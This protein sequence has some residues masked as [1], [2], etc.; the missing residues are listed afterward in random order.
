M[1]IIIYDLETTGLNITED[2]IIEGYF[3]DIVNGTCIHLICDPQVPILPEVSK[4]HGWT[5]LD[6]KGK[7]SFKEEI[8]SLLEFC[9]DK[10][11]FIAHNNDNFDKLMLLTN[12]IKNGYNRPN[13]WKFIDTCKLANIAYPDMDNFKQETLQKKFNISI[14]N[15]HK[16]N[17][18]VLDLYHIY[19]KICN[20]LKLH[21]IDNIIDIWKLSKSWV[22]VKMMYGKHKGTLIKDLP[23]NYKI[24]LKSNHCS[25]RELIKALK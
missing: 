4:I 23:E 16:A 11:I 14:G 13:T 2:K 24:W 7:K 8:P 15:N 3:Y 10:C 18:D 22:P 25:N 9:T 17:K 21:P 20:K 19:E 5:N 12:L 6:L 1:R